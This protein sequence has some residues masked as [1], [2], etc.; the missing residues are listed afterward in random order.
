[1]LVDFSCRQINFVREV[2]QS[3]CHE[4]TNRDPL[5]PTGT[6]DFFSIEQTVVGRVGMENTYRV[7]KSATVRRSGPT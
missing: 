1:M 7:S 4:I 3:L 6:A 5:F 2:E